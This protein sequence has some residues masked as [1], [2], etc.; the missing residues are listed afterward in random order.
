MTQC[1]STKMQQ[2]HHGVVSRGWT[3]LCHAYPI[4]AM[5]AS[6]ALRTYGRQQNAT[7][8]SV[9]HRIKRRQAR[10][11]SFKSGHPGAQPARRLRAI[12]PIE[13]PNMPLSSTGSSLPIMASSGRWGGVATHTITPRQRVS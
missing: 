5:V 6:S 3:S 4:R 2:V 8:T 7:A 9:K 10:C 13:G 12:I 1:L 11:C